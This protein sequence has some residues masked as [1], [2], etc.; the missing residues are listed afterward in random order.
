MQAKSNTGKRT[1]G[2]E[3]EKAVRSQIYPLIVALLKEKTDQEH[4]M[5][6]KMIACELNQRAG[7][8]GGA[9][10]RAENA[11]RSVR[12]WMEELL[13][14]GRGYEEK[15][16]VLNK[17]VADELY[18]A[19]GGRVREDPNGGYWFEPILTAGDISMVNATIISN[20]YLSPKEKAY[21][22]AREEMM[23]SGYNR[24]FARTA[25]IQL[26][27]RPKQSAN[28]M[29]AGGGPAGNIVLENIC[30]LHEAI[31]RKCRIRIVYGEYIEKDG[32]AKLQKKNEGKEAVLN[33]YAL[34]SQ[35]GQYY[36]IVTHENHENPT[37]YR[38]D[39]IWSVE[40]LVEKKDEKTGRLIYRPR[41]E[42]PEVLKDFY[43]NGEFDAEAYTKRYPLMQ[44]EDWKAEE[45]REEYVLLCRHSAISL[46][47]DH[48]GQTFSLEAV[49]EKYGFSRKDHVLLRLTEK[50]GYKNVKLFCIQQNA[51]I[52][53]LGPERLVAEVDQALDEALKRIR[54]LR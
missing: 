42:V 8:G 53:P 35:R 18:K 38:V 47:I 19:Y 22:T 27:P 37:H 45:N 13:E 15:S 10:Y 21:L 12:R 34:V 6:I 5:S 40:K 2:T 9:S 20:R 50:A 23:S 3:T 51:V 1:A 36:L 44:W 14:A 4:P 31:R 17:K 41:N 39:R 16:R 29:A 7:Y 33:P 24:N 43:K 28:T 48:F 52:T 46:V 49:P 54:S 11:E 32:K 26:P 25:P 30:I